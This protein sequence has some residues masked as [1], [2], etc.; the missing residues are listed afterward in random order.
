VDCYN[1]TLSQ[2]LNKHA[3]LK[4]KITRTKPWYTLALKK[5]EL[6]KRHLERIWSHTY[7]FEDLKNL[8]SATN[9]YHAAIIHFHIVHQRQCL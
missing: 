3:P 7:S 9:H 4:C 8:R 1:S 6:A 2:L 5:L